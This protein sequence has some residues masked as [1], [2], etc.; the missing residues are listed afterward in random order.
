MG[1]EVCERER[2]GWGGGWGVGGGGETQKLCLM[3][4]SV[5]HTEI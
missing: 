2:E 4:G 5:Y 3:D 1:E